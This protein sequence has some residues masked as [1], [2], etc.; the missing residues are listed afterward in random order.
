MLLNFKFLVTGRKIQKKL[1][2]ILKQKHL[3]TVYFSFLEKL[4]LL[5]YNNHGNCFK[6]YLKY[7]PV[8]IKEDSFPEI[9]HYFN[10]D[11]PFEIQKEK[12]S[13]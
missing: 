5:P 1:E 7:V 8:L 12:P 6:I 4:I 3:S 11:F 9:P 13:N 10:A 2:E